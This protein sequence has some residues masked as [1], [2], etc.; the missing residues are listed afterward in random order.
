MF[1]WIEFN[2]ILN[3]VY[4]TKSYDNDNFEDT[5]RISLDFKDVPKLDKSRELCEGNIK[6]EE[7]AE[8]LKEMKCNKAIK[9]TT[10]LELNF[11]VHFGM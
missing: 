6:R 7:C 10:T 2:W 9:E 3:L 1:I 5:D 4:F 11:T 8:A